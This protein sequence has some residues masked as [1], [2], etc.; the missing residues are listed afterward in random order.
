MVVISSLEL[1][2]LESCAA[3]D[4]TCNKCNKS[5]QIIDNLFLRLSRPPPLNISFDYSTL[6]K[7][8]GFFGKEKPIQYS[9][10]DIF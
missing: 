8:K 5:F 2:W 10:L 7:F 1:V 6:E 4:Q 3:L 9:L